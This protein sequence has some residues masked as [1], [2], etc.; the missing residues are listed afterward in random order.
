VESIFVRLQLQSQVP[1]GS[2]QLGRGHSFTLS[3]SS[4]AELEDG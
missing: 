1:Q 3:V 4:Y 2:G